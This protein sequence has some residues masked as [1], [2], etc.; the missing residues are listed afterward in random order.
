MEI[1]VISVDLAKNVFQ[2]HGFSALGD[3][4][5]A[6][7][8][9]RKRFMH[10]MAS[11]PQRCEVVM[12]ACSSAHYWGRWLEA[13]GYRVR[14][15]PPQ[16]VRGY[17]VGNKTDGNDT[18]AIY[19]ASR[20]RGLRAVAIKTVAQQDVQLVH[21][22]RERRKKAL[23]ALMNQT[24]GALAER[25]DVCGRGVSA[26]KDLVKQVLAA[27]AEGEISG[28]FLEQLALL[29]AEWRQLEE[30]VAQAE[31]V[32][33]AHFQTDPVC[34]RLAQVPGIGPISAS[35]VAALVGDGRQFRSGRQM[36]AWLGVTPK[37]R[38]S[39]QLRRLG[40]MTKRGDRYLRTMLIHGARAV[41]RTALRKDDARS[42]W[43]QALV[44]RRGYN[45]A[46]VALANK[47]T[48]ILWALLSRGENYRGM[49]QAAV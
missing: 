31:A 26:L 2:V 8:L 1:N 16:H 12:E 34:A 4:L 27:P 42:R 47:N 23:V 49:G 46:A 33:K 40:G 21:R 25:G 9:S 24:R 6:K 17:V 5:V 44:A 28:Y 45:K 22:V 38:S 13:Q 35:A 10:W 36:A 20:R 14:L 29:W 37:E 32:I 19:E 15:I 18:D 30:Q 39:G 7:R 43:I 3:R 11:L 48:R 41:V